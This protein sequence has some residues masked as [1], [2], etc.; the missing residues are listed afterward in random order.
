MKHIL[1][2]I[3]LILSVL[4]RVN[5]SA[6][7]VI[8]A[9]SFCG[10]IQVEEREGISLSKEELKKCDLTLN[11]VDSSYKVLE[12][13]MTMVSKVKGIQPKELRIKG[14]KIPQSSLTLIFNNV[15]LIYLEYILAENHDHVQINIEPVRVHLTD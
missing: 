10:K 3:C 9:A 8:S 1:S 4:I 12:F 15:S 2:C 6:Q 5:T 14:N 13:T 11:A 7:I